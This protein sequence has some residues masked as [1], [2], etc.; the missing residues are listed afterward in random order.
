MSDY[1]IG[2]DIGGTKIASVLINRNGQPI[3]QT[4]CQTRSKEGVD[5]VVERVANSIRE[6]EAAAPG[7]ISGIG[8]GIAGGVD[9]RHATV[10]LAGNLGWEN[11]PI[12]DMLVARLGGYWKG[13]IWA[14]IDVVATAL[15]EMLYGAGRGFKH[16]FYVAVGTGVGV[17]LIL[18]GNPYHGSI[19]IS[20]NFGHFILN[21]GGELCGCG[22]RGCL[23]T[24]A[25]GPA[26]ARRT[27]EALKHGQKSVLSTLNFADITAVEVVAAAKAGDELACHIM[28]ETG[29]Y[30]GIGLAYC[31]DL[32]N[33]ERII[34][35]GGLR[36][37]GDLL[38][39]P[40]RATLDE[41]AVPAIATLIQIVPAKLDNAG[42]IG[43]GSLVW[44]NSNRGQG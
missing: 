33:P 18:D 25:S 34:I 32:L 43:A 19:G 15:G 44:L 3:A 30:L 16:L 17:G 5:A 8:V 10:L 41:W 23:E 40:I 29:R 20:G 31:A 2:V 14:D 28:T 38:F 21:P 26:I 13:R 1:A 36:A 6:L 12:G 7:P 22:K 35:G 9:Y 4:R 11:V 37:A 24:L 39:E 42:A 27:V